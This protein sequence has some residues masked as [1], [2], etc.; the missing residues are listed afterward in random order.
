MDSN[1]LYYFF[2]TSAQVIATIAGLIGAFSVFRLGNINEEINLLK[3]LALDREFL[4]E[5]TLKKT[6][7][8]ENYYNLE[9]VFD[10]DFHSIEVLRNLIEKETEGLFAIDYACDLE[11]IKNN[12][13][14]YVNIKKANA[15][16]FT[17]SMALIF[18]SLISVLATNYLASQNSIYLI[19]GFY[20]M[21]L[22]ILFWL[23]ITQIKTLI[24]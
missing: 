24:S 19:L 18:I 9:K 1:A 21:L 14:L 16:M 10:L 5:K 23:F 2:S 11:N 20:L 12:L 7:V 22:A 3:L 15:Q 6:F 17:Y 8:G 4:P 13:K